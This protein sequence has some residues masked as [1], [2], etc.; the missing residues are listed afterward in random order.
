MLNQTTSLY[1]INL[2]TNY[3]QITKS[4]HEQGTH[5]SQLA[6]KRYVTFRQLIAQKCDKII[7]HSELA[8][9]LNVLATVK[10]LNCCHNFWCVS[11][12]L[13][14]SIKH[15]KLK[16]RVELKERKILEILRTTLDNSIN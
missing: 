9:P 7:S 11:G 13:Y 16:R 6:L 10:S 15:H 12:S 3:K 8:I 5:N 2:A 14:S 4:L 1:F